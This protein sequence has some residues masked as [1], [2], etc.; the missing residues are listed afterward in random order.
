MC[1]GR[2][3]RPDLGESTDCG[4]K[5]HAY[6]N[7]HSRCVKTRGGGGVV[8]NGKLINSHSSHGLNEWVW[9]E[10]YI[11]QTIHTRTYSHYGITI[12]SSS[13]AACMRHV[14]ACAARASFRAQLRV[15]ACCGRPPSPAHV[16]EHACTCALLLFPSRFLVVILR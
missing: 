11:L 10:N 12:R 4:A 13:F 14:S 16:H 8:V 2:S 5:Q 9:A 3:L 15:H 6:A 1:E 7:T